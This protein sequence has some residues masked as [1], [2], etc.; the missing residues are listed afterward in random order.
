MSNDE[1][2]TFYSSPFRKSF[3][4]DVKPISLIFFILRT[5]KT[6]NHQLLTKKTLLRDF[7]YKLKTHRSLILGVKNVMLCP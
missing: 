7:F 1:F 5:S 2:E 4:R 3:Q 6:K